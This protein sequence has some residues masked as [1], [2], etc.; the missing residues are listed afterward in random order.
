MGY[1]LRPDPG[2]FEHVTLKPELFHNKLEFPSLS[3][4]R[5]SWEVFI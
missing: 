2:A 3:L 1:Y 4:R 5:G